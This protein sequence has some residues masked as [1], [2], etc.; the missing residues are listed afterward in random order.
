VTD[1]R[2]KR[3][4]PSGPIFLF[5]PAHC[6]R[7]RILDLEPMG[8]STAAVWRSKPLRYDTL[9][10][11][12]A[13][14]L[15]DDRAVT[16]EI[17]VHDDAGLKAAEQPRQRALTFLN[18]DTTQ[19][20]AVQLDHVEG[21]QFGA[22]MVPMLAEQV[23]HRQAAATGLIVSHPSN[24]LRCVEIS[25]FIAALAVDDVFRHPQ[26]R[27]SDVVSAQAVKNLFVSEN[28]PLNNVQAQNQA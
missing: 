17:L 12:P 19:V 10:A 25:K 15:V 16:F 22:C 1:G 26:L 28:Q 14:V 21:A 3:G 9:T 8:R 24:G 13:R 23:E 11:K 2:K 18:P 7:V 27:F 20:P 5:E 6:R 4:P